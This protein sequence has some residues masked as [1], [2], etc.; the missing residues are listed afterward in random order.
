MLSRPPT[1]PPA[2]PPA[3]DAVSASVTRVVDLVGKLL[4]LTT[5]V[6]AML[7]YLGFVRTNRQYLYFGIDQSMVGLSTADY[8]M[9]SLSLVLGW[10]PY[11]VGVVIVFL[12]T[13]RVVEEL[14]TRWSRS[15]LL[16]GVLVLIAGLLVAI[17]GEIARQGVAPQS[18]D[19]V[20]LWM[21]TKDKI[22]TAIRKPISW[23]IALG[24]I[25]YSIDLLTR[26]VR[27]WRRQRSIIRW[28]VVVL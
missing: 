3:A 26:R 22:W 5:V 12:V 16:V 10:L 7:F 19:E 13:H 18:G 9:R 8:V 23:P 11:V 2:S 20:S 1:P 4:A 25:G 17:G 24:L 27:L 15:P 21:A 6:T 14:A 28:L